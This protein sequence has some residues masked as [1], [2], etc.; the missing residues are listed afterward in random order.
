MAHSI[1]VTMSLVMCNGLALGAAADSAAGFGG[2]DLYLAAP[3]MTVCPQPMPG[4]AH[5]ILLE[6]GASVQIGDNLLTSRNA[7]VWLEPQGTEQAGFG[8]GQAWCVRVYME[9]DVSVQK[10]P[11]SKMTPVQHFMVEGAE[12]LASQFLATGQVFATADTRTSITADYLAD[13]ELYNRGLKGVQQIPSGPALSAGSRVPTPEEV[14]AYPEVKP[15]KTLSGVSPAVAEQLRRPSKSAGSVSPEAPGFPVHLSA[16][17]EPVPRIQ[18]TP[19]PDGREA[20]TASGRF[21]LWQKRSEASLIEFMADNLVIFFEKEQ[22]VLESSKA[23]GGGL[24]AGNVQAVYLSGNIVMTEG[25][26]TTRADEVYYDFVHQRALVVNAS[27]RIYDE[28]RGL[29]VYLRA[30][31]L[32]RVSKDIFEAR[33]VQLTSSEFYFPQISL[34]ASKMVLLTGEAL[35]ARRRLTEEKDVAGQY[36]GHLED[37]T[38]RYGSTPFFKWPRMVTNFARPDIPL[39]RLSVGNDSD[40]GTTVETR[41]KMARLLGIKDPTWKDSQLAVDYFSDRGVGAGVE[42]EY[43]TDDS[44]GSLIGYVMTDRGED[45]LGRTRKN[46]EPDNDVR[47]RFSFRHRQYL[48][49]DWQLTVEVGYLSDRNFLES[50]YRNEFNTGKEEETLVHLKKIWDN[51]AFSILGKIRINDFET[52]TEELPSIEYHRTGQSFWDH[53]LTW[54]SDTQVARFR[55]R[56]DEDAVRG[57]QDT[58]D[59]YTFGTT[60]NEVDL[61]LMWETVKFVPFAA[62]SY[63]YED[64]Y[65]FDRD[66]SGRVIE[67]EDQPVLGETGVRASTIFWK[68]DPY[69]RST[70]FDLKGMRHILTPYA[71][72]VLYEANDDAVDMRDVIHAGLLQRWQTHRGSEQNLRTLDWMRLDIETTWVDDEA[73]DP[74]GKPR[75][76]GPAN[77]I[78]NDPSIPLLLRRDDNFFGQVRDTLNTEYTWRVSDTFTLLSDLNYDIDSGQLQQLDAGVSRYVYPNVSYYVG[79]RYLRPVIIPVDK[80]S[81]GVVDFYEKGS[82]S[83]VGAVT[84]R[85]SPRYVATFSQEYNFDYGKS[86]RSDLALVRQYHR[87]FYAMSFSLDESLDRSSVMF[88]IW[89]QGIKELAVGSRKYTALTGSRWED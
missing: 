43:A 82:N 23:S 13:H 76:Y 42:N 87:M 71:E 33:D 80:N 34:N 19:L 61:P 7:V 8:I 36:E 83:F 46:I 38:A 10:G 39:S 66:I 88:S 73:D 4:W 65:G 86:I 64:N 29:P 12:A 11:K 89:P 72:T 5:A 35:E 79:S 48:P 78:Y 70:L 17:W 67:S 27:M 32:G 77:F 54:Y 84:Y 24:G 63:G 53:R 49:D 15:E 26:R 1:L 52:T 60:R 6:G 22:F 20:I 41:W 25:K 16:V 31:M 30:S 14:I 81:D 21:Y 58:S 75:T 69:Y 28:N 85:L 40:F 55:D 9:G 50:M 2:Q 3:S 68:D 45:D 37:V 44:R 51:Q 47:G 56:F 62:G 18:K 59:F 74:I 57:P